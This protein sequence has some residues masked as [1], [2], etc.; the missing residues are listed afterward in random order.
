ML[1]MKTTSALSLLR[2]LYLLI[3]FAIA[4]GRAHRGSRRKWLSRDRDNVTASP[5]PA[6]SR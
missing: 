3:R 1:V 4:F 6:G 5:I 2:T